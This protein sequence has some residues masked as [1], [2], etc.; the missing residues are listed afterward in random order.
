MLPILVIL[1]ATNAEPV[2]VTSDGSFKQNLQWSPDGSLFLFTRIHKGKMGL[3][4]VKADGSGLKPLLAADPRTP[5][6]DGGFS[7]DG[8]RV[9]FVLDILHGTD[10]KLQVNT[11]A[12]DGTDS[13][14]VIPHKA[15]EESPRFSPDGKRLA[16]V[17]T[18]F[19]NQEVCVIAADGKGEVVRLTN[20]PGFDTNPAWSPDGKKIAFTTSRWGNLEVAVMNADGSGVK[21]LTSHP[22]IDQWPAWS[23]D[24]KRIA[25]TSNRT[26]DY[27]VWVMN[28]DGSGPRNLTRHKGQDNFAAWSPDGKKLAFISNRAGGHDIYV[29]KVD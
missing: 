24:G 5:H 22:G 27:E 14:V 28:A 2:R 13:K 3:W 4:T 23:P 21:R 8:K 1:A 15:F 26:G 29:M 18:R 17:S 9:A 6:F 12:L 10:G 16:W 20:D 25:F 11:C 7:P 19:G